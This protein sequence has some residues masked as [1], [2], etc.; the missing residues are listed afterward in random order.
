MRLHEMEPEEQRATA[1]ALIDLRERPRGD[2]AGCREFD[3]AAREELVGREPATEAEVGDQKRIRVD[4]DRLVPR[5]RQALR[6]RL[7]SRAQHVC[8]RQLARD[9]PGHRLVE[10]P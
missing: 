9:M 10:R 1:V 4:P 8:T 2:G 7:Q 3:L 5:V 6:E